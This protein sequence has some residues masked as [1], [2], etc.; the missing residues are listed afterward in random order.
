M[1]R[2]SG[3]GGSL[4]LDGIGEPIYGLGRPIQGLSVDAIFFLTRVKMDV[5]MEKD[6]DLE[7]ISG[8]DMKIGR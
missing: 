7:S 1:E 2:R 3:V 5:G 8:S 6:A 4:P